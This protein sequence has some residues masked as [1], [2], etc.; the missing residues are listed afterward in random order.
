MEKKDK[1]NKTIP[2]KKKKTLKYDTDHLKGFYP[3]FTQRMQSHER[4]KTKT[5]LIA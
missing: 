2:T 4:I 5:F 3:F 1:K